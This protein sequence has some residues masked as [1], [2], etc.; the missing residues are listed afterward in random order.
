MA[1]FFRAAKDEPVRVLCV[2]VKIGLGAD[3]AKFAF[4]LLDFD[5]D[6]IV[7]SSKS[8]EQHILLVAFAVPH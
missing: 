6:E 3:G 7:D 8:T 2:G 4:R 5:H 1:P